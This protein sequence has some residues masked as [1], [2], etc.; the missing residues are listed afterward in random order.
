MGKKNLRICAGRCKRRSTKTALKNLTNQYLW[1][2]QSINL[3][4]DSS[5]KH[6][7]QPFAK[8]NQRFE[9]TVFILNYANRQV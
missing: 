6:S 3:A 2:I 8:C 7:Q 5:S 1:D 4:D 9:F